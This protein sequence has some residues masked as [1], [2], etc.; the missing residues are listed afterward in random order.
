MGSR[1]DGRGILFGGMPNCDKSIYTKSRVV[2]TEMPNDRSHRGV[3]TIPEPDAMT[4]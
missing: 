2:D 4:E 3:R 1:R